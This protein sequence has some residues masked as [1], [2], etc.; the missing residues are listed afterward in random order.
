MENIFFLQMSRI[1][2]ILWR[3]SNSRSRKKIRKYFFYTDL[4]EYAIITTDTKEL[5]KRKE[6]TLFRR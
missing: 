6:N 4:P 2:E 5:F 1:T 3:K